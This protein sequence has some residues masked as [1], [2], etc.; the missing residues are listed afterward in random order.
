MNS[1]NKTQPSEPLQPWYLY[2]IQTGYQQLYTGISTDWK[3][4]LREHMQ[5]GPKTAKALRGKGPLT[6]KY[7]VELANHSVALQTEI[8]VKKQSRLT[9]DKIIEGE[10]IL[11][12]EHTRVDLSDYLQKH[13]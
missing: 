11:A 7:C 3:R 1:T 5:N 9:K 6:L 8:W 13:V 10:I 2:M 12:V 4:R